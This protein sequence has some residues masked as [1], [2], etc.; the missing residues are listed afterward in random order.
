MESVHKMFERVGYKTPHLIY[1]NVNAFKD[2]ILDGTDGVTYVSGC[3]PVIFEQILTGKRGIDLM[4]DKLNS[5][6]YAPIS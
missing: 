4:Y 3:S 2:T 5:E 1:W 6:R